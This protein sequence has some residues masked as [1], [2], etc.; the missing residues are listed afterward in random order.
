[1]KIPDLVNVN[2]DF[3]YQWPKGKPEHMV[4]LEFLVNSNV[5]VGLG[6]TTRFVFGRYRKRW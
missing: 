2:P 3:E 5:R 1:M 6:F 4:L